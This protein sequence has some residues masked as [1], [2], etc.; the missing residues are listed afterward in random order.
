MSSTDW[1]ARGRRRARASTP[2]TETAAH[3]LD[4]AGAGW[5]AVGLVPC[6][7]AVVLLVLRRPWS[8]L[9]VIL[10]FGRERAQRASGEDPLMDGRGPDDILI[11]GLQRRLSLGHA[12]AGHSTRRCSRR[13][14]C[15]SS[16]RGWWTAVAGHQLS[17]RGHATLGRTLLAAH[18]L[19]DIDVGAE[20]LGAGIVGAVGVIFADRSAGPERRGEPAVGT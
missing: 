13:S 6:V 15:S 18:W 5:I 2:A 12:P 19:I 14:P 10:A 20:L 8:A 1:T 17:D 9:V 3:A 7:L 11:E 4:L 16:S